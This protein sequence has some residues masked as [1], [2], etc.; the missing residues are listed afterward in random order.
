MLFT[1]L[2]RAATWREALRRCQEAAAILPDDPRPLLYEGLCHERLTR[3]AQSPE[4][5]QKEFALSE[6]TLRK[7]L[8]LQVSSPD[9]SPV[10]T[11]RALA[12]I[13]GHMNDYR[14]ALDS[15]KSAR[16]ADTLTADTTELDGEIRSIE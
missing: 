13:Y 5:K 11:Y 7:A 16:Q 3:L 8:T 12:S 4:E 6:A 9:Y 1:I 10:L 2:G 14:A 15:L